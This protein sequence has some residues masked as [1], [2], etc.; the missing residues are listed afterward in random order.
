MMIDDTERTREWLV[1][2]RSS[3]GSEVG[4]V[5]YKVASRNYRRYV[6]SIRIAT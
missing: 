3:L 6:S 2:E 5:F 4:M 1:A